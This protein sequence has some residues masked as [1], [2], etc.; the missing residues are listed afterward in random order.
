M[1]K[2]EYAVG[3]NNNVRL[4]CLV[5]NSIG[6]LL[7]LIP[8]VNGF[9]TRFS[10][11]ERAGLIQPTSIQGVKHRYTLL[12]EVQPMVNI[13]AEYISIGIISNSYYINCSTWQ[14]ACQ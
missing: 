14:T 3:L 2:V 6:S 12:D 4:C 9:E 1:V 7:T 5:H 8:C 10:L 13:L 11:I